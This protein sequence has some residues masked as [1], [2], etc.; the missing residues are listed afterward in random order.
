MVEYIKNF[1]DVLYQ[2][3]KRPGLFLGPKAKNITRLST[4]LNG[5]TFAMGIYKANDTLAENFYKLHDYTAK[6]F[7]KYPTGL[8][9]PALMLEH[10]NGDQEKAFELF[11]LI[12]QDFKKEI[13]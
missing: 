1:S 5:F 13:L 6:R 2:I 3:E 12:L 8:G 10:C 7:N 4:Y 11:Y 9:W